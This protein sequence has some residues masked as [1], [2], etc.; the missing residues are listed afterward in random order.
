MD[1]DNGGLSRTGNPVTMELRSTLNMSKITIQLH[2]EPIPPAL[3][4]K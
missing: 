4:G 1:L 3:A 2:I